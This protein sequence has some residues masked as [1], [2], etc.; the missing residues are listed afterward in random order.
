MNRGKDRTKNF[1]GRG[2][3]KSLSPTEVNKQDPNILMSPQRYVPHRLPVSS[4]PL[5]MTYDPFS[6]VESDTS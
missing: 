2:S 5:F 4:F 6:Y 1:C 3:L